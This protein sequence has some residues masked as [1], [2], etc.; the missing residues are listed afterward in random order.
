MSLG[1]WGDEGDVGDELNDGY[2][3]DC[4][5]AFHLDDCG[6]YNPPCNCGQCDGT[7]CRSCCRTVA[8]EDEDADWC[9]DDPASS[10]PTPEG[11]AP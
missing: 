10:V 1:A 8:T 4:G 7:I 11:E 6:G 2:C 3:A 9:E 5:D